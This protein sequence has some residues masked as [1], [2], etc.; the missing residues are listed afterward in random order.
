L[1]LQRGSGGQLVAWV[2][3]V[4]TFLTALFLVS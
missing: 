3:G 2:V 1:P 4:M